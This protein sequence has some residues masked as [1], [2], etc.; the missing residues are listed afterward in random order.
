MRTGGSD[1]ANDDLARLFGRE[2]EEI[3][4]ALAELL[5]ASSEG[6]A[7]WVRRVFARVERALLEHLHAEET[8][9]FP[10]IAEDFP[11]EVATLLEQHEA[12]R[13]AWSSLR[14]APHPPV[15][16]IEALRASMRDHERREESLAYGQAEHRMSPFD[17]PDIKARARRR[18]AR[19][20]DAWTGTLRRSG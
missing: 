4:D 15:V 13:C 20:L 14:A 3:D 11:S 9:I 1:P 10:L 19:H 7:P 8:Q 5:A 6:D 12:I 16:E 17:R 2:H 18:L